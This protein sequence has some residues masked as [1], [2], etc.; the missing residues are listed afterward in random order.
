M[1]TFK[2][3]L[4]EMSHTPSSQMAMAKTARDW[5]G[6]QKVYAAAADVIKSGDSV[7][8]FGSGPY[9]GAKEITE[10][11]GGIYTAHDPGHGITGD[12]TKKYNVVLAS[13]V[14]NV[15]SKTDTPLTSYNFIL[16]L[17]QKITSTDGSLI[18]NMPTSGP[19]AEWMSPARLEADLKSRFTSVV[20]KGELV[21]ARQ[22]HNITP[23][24]LKR[25]GTILGRN[26]SVG[27]VVW[28]RIYLH[29]NYAESQIGKDYIRAKSVFDAAGLDWNY[30]TVSYDLTTGAVTFQEAPGFDS[31]SEPVVGR[32]IT[33]FKDGSISKERNE[34]QI[35]HHKWQWVDDN[36]KGFDVEKSKERSQSY[37]NAGITSPSGRSNIFAKQLKDANIINK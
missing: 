31:S 21:Y 1:I 14:L 7:M 37:R 22:P 6:K 34:T 27:K 5:G 11:R 15:Q 24:P 12:L 28:K 29:R 3:F 20:R 13:N 4:A 33:I 32:M 36:Y 30:N 19:K 8:D 25:G 26:F 9:G 17:L 18:V 35:Y 10:N 16:N 23:T 2:R